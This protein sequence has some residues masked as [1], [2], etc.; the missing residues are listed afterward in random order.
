MKE[1]HPACGQRC[2]VVV[3]THRMP[4]WLPSCLPLHPPGRSWLWPHQCTDCGPTSDTAGLAGCRPAHTHT[5]TQRV[6]HHISKLRVRYPGRRYWAT[7][8]QLGLEQSLHAQQPPAHPSATRETRPCRYPPRAPLLCTAGLPTFCALL[9]RLCDPPPSCCWCCFSSTSPCCCC[10]WSCWCAASTTA[11]SRLMMG[12]N[13][14]H[15]SWPGSSSRPATAGQ[16]SMHACISGC[17][18]KAR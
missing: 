4:P 8:G 7:P 9:L 2:R 14:K 17:G 11:K 18:G 6:V 15:T 13:L 16:N 12:Q 3:G 10:C 1:K 5:Y